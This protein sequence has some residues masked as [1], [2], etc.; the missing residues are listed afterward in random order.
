LSPSPPPTLVYLYGPPA[1][2][3]L[4]IATRLASL[5]GFRLFHNHLTVSAVAP[6]FDFGTEPFGDVIHRLRLDVF[7]TAARHG[8]DVIFTNSNAWSGDEPRARFA[9]FADQVAALV[10][11]AGGRTCF[12]CV[13][14]PLPVL[15]QR[16][17]VESRRVH[18]KLADPER[19]RHLVTTIDLSPLHDDDLVIDSSAVAPDEAAARI[20]ARL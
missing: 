17:G 13:R 5:T 4:T 12:V 14:A 19:L 8:V 6:V 3:K 11:G 1:A 2:G 18:G 7:E 10:D 9:A 20:A 16:L 15:L